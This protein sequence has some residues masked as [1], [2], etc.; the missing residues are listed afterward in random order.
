M[1]ILKSLADGQLPNAKGTLYTVPSNTRAAIK[2]LSVFNNNSTAE[3]VVIYL[4]RSGSTSRVIWRRALAANEGAYVIGQ[5]EAVALSAADII[6]GVTTTASQ[7]DYF[8][9]GVELP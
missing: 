3:T 8:I 7:V 4:K 1:A 6:E 5:D 2:F 9:S